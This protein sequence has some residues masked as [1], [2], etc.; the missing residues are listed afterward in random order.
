MKPVQEI[1]DAHKDLAYV[2]GKGFALQL[3]YHVQ[4]HVIQKD[5]TVVHKLYVELL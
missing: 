2:M 3:L 4:I 1:L 5:M